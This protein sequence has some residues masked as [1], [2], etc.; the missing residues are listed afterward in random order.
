M[1]EHERRAKAVS[2]VRKVLQDK[3]MEHRLGTSWE[4]RATFFAH[5]IALEE[6]DGCDFLWKQG[7]ASRRYTKAELLHSLRQSFQVAVGQ[8]RRALDDAEGSA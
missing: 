4:D 1:K 5:M 2:E 6:V 8:A 7:E 3:M